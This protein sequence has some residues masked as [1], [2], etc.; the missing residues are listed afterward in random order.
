MIVD[1]H[2]HLLA[3][4]DYVPRLLDENA[5]LGIDRVCLS[6]LSDFPHLFS[7]GDEELPEG[8]SNDDV[9]RAFEKYPDRVTGFAYFRLG[10]DD[11]RLSRCSTLRDLRA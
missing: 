8:V 2:H 10:R 1:A 9:R 11:P 7:D 3:I 4:K 5:C 6:A